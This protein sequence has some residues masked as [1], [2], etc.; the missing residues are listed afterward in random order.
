MSDKPTIEIEYNFKGQVVA[1]I[2]GNPVTGI[3]NLHVQEE[4]R[5]MGLGE[6]I[7]KEYIEKCREK[8][9]K[10]VLLTCDQ[11]NIPA[12]SL[13]KKLKFICIAMPDQTMVCCLNL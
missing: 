3:V 5:G 6:K 2:T 4:Y 7:L 13:Y 12:V 9:Y 1:S 11:D 8:G 10:K